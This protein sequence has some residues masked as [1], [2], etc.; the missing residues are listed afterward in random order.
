MAS[1]ADTIEL[2][3]TRRSRHVWLV[4]VVSVAIFVALCSLLA[5]GLNSYLSNVTI[6]QTASLESHQGTQLSVTRYGTLAPV[7]ITGRTDLREGD[8]TSTGPDSEGFIQLFNGASTVQTYFSTTLTIDRLRT[9][10]FFQDVKEAAL[11][12]VEGT[13]VIATA[14]NADN[15]S[16]QY[17]VSTLQ[18]EVSI[19][20]GSNVRLATDGR[21]ESATTQVVV[22]YG[23]AVVRSHG[24]KV[25]LGAS[26]MVSIQGN[27]PPQGPVAA[28]T[29][30]IHNGNFNEPPTSPAE[31]LENGGLGTAAWQPIRDDTAGN[32]GSVRV[33]TETVPGFGQVDAA[34]ISGGDR[35]ARIGL[36]QDIN[37]PVDFMRTIQLM[38]TVKIA[39]QGFQAGGPQ[40]NLFPLTIRVLYTDAKGNPQEWTHSFYYTQQPSGNDLLSA[41][42]VPLAVW[43]PTQQL[44]QKDQFTLKS[45]GAQDIAVINSIEIYGYGTQFQSWITGVSMVGK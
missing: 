37:Q 31:R 5:I 21:A 7:L 22:D 45:S 13:I 33:L 30:L 14:E 38:A 27:N 18:A 26:Q 17:S 3:T 20:S 9:T 24:K 41:S 28:A 16:V 8:T 12:L 25:E 23:S 32:V 11:T 10:R 36:R 34:V 29:E 40:G 19:G 15:A 42:P 1:P 4:I 6:P 2:A 43:T 44:P 39:A 35:F